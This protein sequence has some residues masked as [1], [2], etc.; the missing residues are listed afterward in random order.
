M[1]GVWCCNRRYVSGGY[2]VTLEQADRKTELKL[3]QAELARTEAAYELSSLGEKREEEW[4]SVGRSALPHRA[5]F[6]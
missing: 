3:A 4:R 6:T 2:A 5:W 1:D